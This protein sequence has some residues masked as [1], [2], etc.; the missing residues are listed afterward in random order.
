[1]DLS[2]LSLLIRMQFKTKRITQDRLDLHQQGMTW[3]SSI[4]PHI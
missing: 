1:M 2:F 4:P 3:R